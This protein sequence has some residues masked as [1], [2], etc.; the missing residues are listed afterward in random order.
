MLLRDLQSW[1][2]DVDACVVDQDVDS[3]KATCRRFDHGIDA[4]QRS[5]LQL[6]GQ[7]SAVTITDV[8]Y[9]TNT[10]TVDTPLSWETGT[11]VSLPYAGSAPDQG[12]YELEP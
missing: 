9:A 10:I 6:E 12:A 11:G 5:D 4:L 2:G 1:F 7:S 3:T 8:D